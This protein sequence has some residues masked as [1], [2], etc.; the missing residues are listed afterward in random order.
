MRLVAP[1]DLRVTRPPAVARWW[2][3]LVP[4]STLAALLGGTAGCSGGGGGGDGPTPICED[5]FWN[6]CGRTCECPEGTRCKI[7]GAGPGRFCGADCDHGVACPSDEVCVGYYSHAADPPELVN[8]RCAP[9]C[10]D[11]S[12]CHDGWECVTSYVDYDTTEPTDICQI[13][14]S[15]DPPPRDAGGS[16]PCG[17]CGT[18]GSFGECCG[19]A[20]CAGDCIGSPCC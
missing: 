4:W 16:D 11:D 6:Q 10:T 12:S 3:W 2:R 19:G 14:R 8:P 5:L 15:D 1:S 17:R 20:Y 7:N 9:T 13:A 18:F